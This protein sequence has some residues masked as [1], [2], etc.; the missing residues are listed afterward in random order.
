MKVIIAGG[1]NFNNYELLKST[2]ENLD[3]NITEIV[4]GEAKGADTLGRRYAE[5]KNIPIK[6]FPAQWDTYGKSAGMIRNAEMGT[7]ADYLVAFWDGKSRG[8]KNMID[9]MKN[10]KK[11]GYVK[12]Y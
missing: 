12:Y 3:I 4:C 11:H 6:S 5:E 7:Y 2:I 8:T 9:Y 1:R 10:H